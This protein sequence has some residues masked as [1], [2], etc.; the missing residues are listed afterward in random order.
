M[1]T[2]VDHQSSKNAESLRARTINKGCDSRKTIHRFSTVLSL[3]YCT[4][5]KATSMTEQ[6]MTWTTANNQTENN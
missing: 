4:T 5:L 2:V 1:P 3:T 6:H